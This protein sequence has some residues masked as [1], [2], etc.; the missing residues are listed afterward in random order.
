MLK[1]E[2]LRIL[3]IL[4]LNLPSATIYIIKPLTKLVQQHKIRFKVVLE[5][6]VTPAQIRS[7]DLILFCRNCEPSF[8][9]VLEECLSL[10]IPT[11]FDLDDNFWEIPFDLYYAKTLRAPERLNQLEK[12]LKSV[13]LVR[14]YSQKLFE[15]VLQFNNNI[16]LVTPGIDMSLVPKTALPR[17]DEKIRITYVTGR[18]SGDELISLFSEDLMKILDIYHDI[19]EMY[20]WG[21]IPDLFAKYPA[22]KLVPIID[23]YEKYLFYLSHGSFD[24]GLAPLT[25][26]NFNLSKTNTKFRDYGSCRIAG[27]YSNVQVYS[28]CVQHEKNG[29]LVDIKPGSWFEAIS[30]LINEDELRNGIEEAA[31]R[32]VEKHY[33]QEYLENQW[34]EIIKSFFPTFHQDVID[35]P[36]IKT[37]YLPKVKIKLGYEKC[38]STEF[39]IANSK[40]KPGVGVIMDFSKPFPFASGSTDVIIIEPSNTDV[41]MV[42]EVIEEI[43]RISKHLAQVCIYAPYT[44][45]DFITLDIPNSTVFNEFTPSCWTN[46]TPLIYQQ[47]WLHFNEKVSI[48]TNPSH[49]PLIDLRCV[50]I[51]FFYAP[52]FLNLH[53][54]ERSALRLEK[55]GV[56]EYVLYHLLALKKNLSE[57]ELAQIVKEIEYIEPISATDKRL[58]NTKEALLQENEKIRQNLLTVKQE[59]S[60]MQT[61]L[62]RCKIVIK[63]KD[64]CLEVRDISIEESKRRLIEK[65]IELEQSL[66]SKVALQT[67]LDQMEQS[68]HEKEKEL[69]KNLLT[70]NTKDIELEKTRNSLTFTQITLNSQI[71]LAQ[72]MT[73]ELDIFRNRKIFRFLDRLFNRNDVSS[74]LPPI[75]QNL[76]DDSRI[77]NNNLNQYFLQPSQNLQR[78]PYLSYRL[79]LNQP[80]LYK[81]QLA[82]VLETLPKEGVFGLEIISSEN[83]IVTSSVVNASQIMLFAPVSLQFDPLGSISQTPLELRVF[84]RGFDIPIYIYEWRTYSFFGLGPVCT[85][86]FCG[87]EFSQSE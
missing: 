25:D 48:K 28:S 59:I 84:A 74:N 54:W 16:C 73:K 36:Y 42:D 55:S 85:Q 49:N 4:P 20:W 13:D 15:R 24:I 17:R 58:S 75:Y 29:L 64:I 26:S 81:V 35:Q 19:V 2:L 67:Q 51:E 56:C 18:G 69:D 50:K 7:S 5:T 80:N 78:V 63:E 43:F 21:E 57:K 71:H 41:Q 76:L 82:P 40:P 68:L 9:W 52:D 32:Y 37:V 53:N 72:I 14:V 1:N 33:R 79:M 46:S 12:F 22:S 6:E 44:P 70:I 11:V 47:P 23:D 39:I 30:R 27:I 61:E 3:L 38:L 86:A 8:N 83:N 87:F 66:Q 65:T 31:Y 60:K 62:D 45:P 77:Y 10:G 34:L